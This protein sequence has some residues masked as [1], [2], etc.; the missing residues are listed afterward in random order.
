MARSMTILQLLLSK[1]FDGS[2][3]TNKKHGCI[4]YLINIKKRC[5]KKIKSRDKN[6]AAL[7]ALLF[8]KSESDRRPWPSE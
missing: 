6:I 1:G 8:N 3:K 7:I 4:N 2:D 5:I